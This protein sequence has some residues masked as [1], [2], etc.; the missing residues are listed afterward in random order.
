MRRFAADGGAASRSPPFGASDCG[1]LIALLRACQ[2][3]A[4]DDAKRTRD[5]CFPLGLQLTRQ[6]RAD[7][8]QPAKPNHLSLPCRAERPSQR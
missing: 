6:E 8:V 7:I 3:R 1:T 2:P 5:R 4:V